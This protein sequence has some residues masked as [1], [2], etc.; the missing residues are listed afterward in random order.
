MGLCCI[1]FKAHYKAE[2]LLQTLCNESCP[3]CMTPY[4]RERNTTSHLCV[5]CDLQSEMPQHPRSGL[6]SSHLSPVLDRPVSAAASITAV[7]TAPTTPLTEH[8]DQ[9]EDGDEDESEE[10]I[11]E[12]E[13]RINAPTSPRTADR[14]AKMDHAATRLGE[15]MLQGYSMSATACPMDDCVPSPL[16]GC[17][18]RLIE[19]GA[20]PFLSC[21]LCERRFT[22]DPESGQLRQMP[23]LHPTEAPAITS[24]ASSEMRSQTP[25]VEDDTLSVVAG[26]STSGKEVYTRQK[27]PRTH[28]VAMGAVSG[29]LS[30]LDG[31]LSALNGRLQACTSRMQSGELPTE[32][33][34]AE[35]S[36]LSQTI[37][38][39]LKTAL[40]ARRFSA[41]QS[42]SI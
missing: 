14:R 7:S 28:A 13:R 16:V 19:P 10:A 33:A 39:V 3:V 12:L 11:A 20:V 9:L 40:R 1:C 37:E 23:D 32:A 38:R 29:T 22:H 36:T 27:R 21:V 31:T 26:P 24:E 35:I 8:P 34:C 41:K 6:N 2:Y 18:R 4:V 30:A 15:M 42:E 17:P 25:E 5:L